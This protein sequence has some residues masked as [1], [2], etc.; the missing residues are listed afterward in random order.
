VRTGLEPATLGVTG[1][2][3][4]QTELPHQAVNCD[5]KI[6][7]FFVN[8]KCFLKKILL[9]EIMNQLIESEKA[10]IDTSIETCSKKPTEPLNVT[11]GMFN[12]QYSAGFKN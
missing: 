2:Y 6:A 5:A 4:N 10:E 3:S 8:A 9:A 7:D 12:Y 11:R 1:R